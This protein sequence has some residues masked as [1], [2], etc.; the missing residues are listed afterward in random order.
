MVEFATDAL[1]TSHLRRAVSVIHGNEPSRYIV[2]PNG[3]K[4]I[5]A[6]GGAVVP[7]HPMAYPYLVRF[8]HKPDNVQAL[9]VELI[10]E[11]G[12]EGGATAVAVC[13]SNTSTWDN[14]YFEM[15]KAAR[16]EEICHFMPQNYLLWVSEGAQ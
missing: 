5:G 3:I 12:G 14:R 1:G 16:G 2:A 13:H 15:L 9:S 8:C 10:G 6:P 7:C 4:R 11:A